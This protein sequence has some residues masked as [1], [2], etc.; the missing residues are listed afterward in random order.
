MM[1]VEFVALPSLAPP[2]GAAVAAELGGFES[3]VLVLESVALAWSAAKLL[4]R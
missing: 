2:F 4:H 1:G 3:V